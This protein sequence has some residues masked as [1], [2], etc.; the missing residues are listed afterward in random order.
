MSGRIIPD[1][2]TKETVRAVFKGDIIGREMIFYEVTS[3]TNDRAM[4]IARQRNSGVDPGST[5]QRKG[6]DGIV[7]IADAQECGRGRF[8]RDWISPAGMNLYFTVLL[9]PAFSPKEAS[10]VTLMASVAV[11]SAIREHVNQNVVIK[12]P[13]DILI[14]AKKIGGI[15]TEMK[16]SGGSISFIA[17][18]VGINVNMPLNMLPDDIRSFAASLKAETGEN[19]NRVQLLGGVL[20]KLEYWYKILLEGRREALLNEWMILNSTIGNKVSVKTRGT[21]ISGKAE[22]ISNN[23]ELLLRLSSGTLEKLCSGEVTILKDSR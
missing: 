9:E 14:G 19:I 2:L 5:S 10:I 7:I 23:G 4:E 20:T 17:L 11:V 3:S 8:G 12:W 6:I 15:L 16:T 13:N 22:G 18:G 1:I 21:V